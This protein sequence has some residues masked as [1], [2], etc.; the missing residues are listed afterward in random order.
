M[1]TI[2]ITGSNKGIG[3]E[4][5]RQLGKLGHHVV[6]SGRNQKRVDEA[7]EKLAKEMIVVDQLVM[8]VIEMGS[9]E[10]AATELSMLPISISSRS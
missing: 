1:K 10:S 6:I 5:A 8:D 7:I 2:L 4:T 9:I 3:F